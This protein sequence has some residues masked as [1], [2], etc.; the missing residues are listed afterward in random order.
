SRSLT[1]CYYM[2]YQRAHFRKIPG[3]TGFMVSAFTTKSGMPLSDTVRYGADGY[4]LN[5]FAILP[6]WKVQ[7]VRKR[8]SS[9]PCPG[10]NPGKSDLVIFGCSC[11]HLSGV[12][13]LSF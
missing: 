5:L 4:G 9:Y 6:E 3:A 7:T 8:T 11:S 1:P 2:S 10:A 13:Y 12:A